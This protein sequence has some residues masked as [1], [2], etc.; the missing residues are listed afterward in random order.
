MIISKKHTFSKT[1]Q[2]KCL[3]LTALD[4]FLAITV[5]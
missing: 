5:G 2:I 1:V 4:P 3:L